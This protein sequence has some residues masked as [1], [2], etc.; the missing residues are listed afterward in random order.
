M[1]D[2]PYISI[3]MNG[4]VL[5]IPQTKE[6]PVALNYMIE[7]EDDF[8]QKKAD[9][10]FDITV[11][12]T[13]N[14]SGKL[15]TLFNPASEVN[16]DDPVDVV[17]VSAGNEI[18]HGKGFVTAGREQ[19][20]KPLGFDIDVYGGNADWVIPNKELTLHDVINAL[21]H[22]FDKT[23]I[24]ASFGHNGTDENRFFVY[25]PVRNREP[26]GEPNSADIPDDI[27]RP[28]NARPSL[29]I[30]WLLYA[31][32]KRQGYQ[33]S[34]TFMNTNYFRRMVMPWTWGSFL[35][36]NSPELDILKF[37]A[38]NV[39][40]LYVNA[41]GGGTGS[42]TIGTTQALDQSN[43]STG[44]GFDNGNGYTFNTVDGGMEFE[45]QPAYFTQFGSLIIGFRLQFGWFFDLSLNSW[46]QI[47]IKWYLDTGA[48]W[49]LQATTMTINHQAPVLGVY[50]G[51][52][53]EVSYWESPA[54]GSGHKVKA[55]FAVS[56]NDSALGAVNS[57]IIGHN[58]SGQNIDGTTE[59]RNQYFKIPIGGTVDFKKYE[60]LK[61]YK[62]LDLLRGIID[63]FNLQLN[64]DP[65]TKTVVIEPTHKHSL[66]ASIANPAS[67]GYYNG[68]VIDWT[69]KRDI[70][71]VSELRLYQDYERETMI[72]LKE[73][74]NDG[75]LKL[76][77]DRIKGNLTASKYVFPARF[78][79]GERLI[80]NRFFSGVTHYQALAWKDI[81]GVVPQLICLIP[82]NIANT[83]NPSSENVFLPKIA[84][85]KGLVDPNTFGGWNWD[86]DT[87]TDLPYMFAVNYKAGGEDDP[88]LTYCDQ[89]IDG[90]VTGFGLFKRFLWQRFAIMRH[91]KVYASSF[92]LN[93]TDVINRLHREFKQIQQNRYQLIS[94]EGYK[95]MLNESTPCTLWKFYP[96]TE[97]DN[98][99][100]FP[101]DQS[102]QTEIP[103][104][105]TPDMKYIRLM[106]LSS[107]I[108]Q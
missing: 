45:Y 107:D 26:F 17:I 97:A 29:F 85:Y 23:T 49:V 88:I 74:S 100:T 47:D 54:L 8:R 65:V 20:G 93:N 57:I 12:A 64:T 92:V 43:D 59:F 22:T 53:N 44:G 11:P 36:L 99:N 19:D 35:Y 46:A 68:N 73:D 62:W 50:Q 42:T 6:L 106:A 41:P 4:N 24:E 95:P 13:P 55:E 14:N 90:G 10:G 71:K 66:T 21:T 83:S 78:R 15:T 37:K 34:S 77:N 76:L 91:G 18:M 80:E 27:F 84:F 98:D 82:E 30:Y 3:K 9:S 39:D 33:I 51:G 7:A 105:N 16:F 56:W 52:G 89:R 94:I 31:G 32:F 104:I 108:P 61:K 5:D 38:L 48:G 28:I 40:S 72:Q 86:G 87:T 102:V 75:I 81:T 96:V 69:E 70:S 79:K 101:S 60:N 67:Q 58:V 2:T 1:A 25:A 63:T 103:I